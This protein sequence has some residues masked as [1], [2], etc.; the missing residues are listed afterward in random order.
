MFVICFF[1]IKIFKIIQLIYILV[2]VK[3]I[4]HSLKNKTPKIYTYSFSALN[5][6]KNGI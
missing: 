6:L 1:W 3:K 4:F 5:Y 2:D